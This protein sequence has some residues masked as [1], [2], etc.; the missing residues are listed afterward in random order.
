MLTFPNSQE[1]HYL[2]PELNYINI[3]ENAALIFVFVYKFIVDSL[4]TQ[5]GEQSNTRWLQSQ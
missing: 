2:T 1:V 3:S 5:V 4:Y